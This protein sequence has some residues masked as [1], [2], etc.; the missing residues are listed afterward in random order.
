MISTAYELINGVFF[1]GRPILLVMAYYCGVM[2]INGWRNQRLIRYYSANLNNG[3][4]ASNDIRAN[5]LMKYYCQYSDDYG[6]KKRKWEYMCEMKR[7][8]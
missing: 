1:N 5:Q 6:V 3:G 2:G 4:E 7:K 8:Q